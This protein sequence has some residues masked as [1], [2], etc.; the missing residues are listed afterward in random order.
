MSGNDNKKWLNEYEAFLSAEDAVVPREATDKV[1]SQM[2]EL[3]NPSAWM[4][5]FKVLAI[6]LT[7]GFLSLSVCHQFGMNPFGTESSL[8]DWFMAMWGHSTCMI[9]CGT[10][11]LSASILTAGYFL[12]VEEVKALKRTELLQA[13]SLGSIS[14]A[15]FAIFGAELAVTFAGLWLLGALVGGFVATEAVW[16]LKRI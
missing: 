9:A 1:F 13:L 4:V 3:I 8:D 16:K 7:V 15:F 6:H 10:L 11:F 5:F 2:Q 14:L 12:S